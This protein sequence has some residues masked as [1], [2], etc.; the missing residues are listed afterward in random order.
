MSQRSRRRPIAEMN[1]VP[2][3]DVMLV[4]LV[5]FMITAPLLTQ[6]VKVELPKV[7]AEPMDESSREPLVITVDSSGQLFLNLGER[8]DAPIGEQLLVEKVAAVLRRQP[9]IPVLLRGDRNVDYG[10]VVRAMALL[11]EAGAPSIGMVTETPGAERRG[12]D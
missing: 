1:V 11:Q 12:R 9:D 4:L 8:P 7:A 6:G 10:A 3:I 2:Y 5:I